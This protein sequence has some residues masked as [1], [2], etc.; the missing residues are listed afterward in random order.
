VATKPCLM[1]P[2]RKGVHRDCNSEVDLGNRLS[3]LDPIP[4][5]GTAYMEVD[6]L[7]LFINKGSPACDPDY[8]RGKTRR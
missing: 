1:S 5:F 2:F 3:S 4:L 8:T 7:F 6:G